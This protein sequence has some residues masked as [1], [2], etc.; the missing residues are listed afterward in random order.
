MQCQ[1]RPRLSPCA[2]LPPWYNQQWRV[3]RFDE[4][5][6][7]S[8]CIGA[9]MAEVDAEL[10]RVLAGLLDENRLT[11]IEYEANGVRVRVGRGPANVVAAAPVLAMPAPSVA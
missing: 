8:P 10:I 7:T 3:R 5:K 9:L 2:Q 1:P 4:R 11:E 6:T